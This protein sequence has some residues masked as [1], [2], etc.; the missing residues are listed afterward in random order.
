MGSG[1]TYVQPSG[2]AANCRSRPVIVPVGYL[3][4][5][6]M[7]VFG[8]DTIQVRAAPQPTSFW[9]CTPQ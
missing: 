3:Q 5:D 1:G 4:V 2:A 6:C 8:R 9:A 7:R